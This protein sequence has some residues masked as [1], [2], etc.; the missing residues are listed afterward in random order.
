MS[1]DIS[2]CF[3]QNV[4]KSTTNSYRKKPT[5][6][7]FSKGVFSLIY[8]LSLPAFFSPTFA[9]APANDST[10]PVVKVATF[11]VS[12][13]ATNY[14]KRGEVGKGDELINSLNNNHQQ[15]K[16]IAEII[17][18]V[19]PDILLLNEFDYIQDPNQGIEKFISNYLNVSQ[20][21]AQAI[22]Y[23][24]YYYAPVNT[25]VSTNFDLDNNGEKSGNMADAYGFGHFPGHFGMVLVSRYPID[26]K[27]IRTFQ[28]F[29]WK[30]MPNAMKPT[31]PSTGKHWYSEQEWQALRLSSKSHWDIPVN[32]NGKVVHVLTSHP[33][34]PVFDGPEDRNGA[35]NHDEIRFWNDY[36][37][38]NKASYIY[39]DNG[40]KGGIITGASFVIMGDQNASPDEGSAIKSGI[41]NLLANPLTNNTFTP[42]S[43]GGEKNSES[44]FA[45][46][47]TAA[48]K[49]RADYV[50]PSTHGIKV[51]AAGV[52]WPKQDEPLY[53]LIETRA[54]SSDHRLVWVALMLNE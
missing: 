4:K 45:K 40:K 30:E 42:E 12:M 52:F 38:A 46:S 53:R 47:H 34:P 28:N 17:Q 5:K 50:I 13:D 3:T 32:V 36:I 8:L 10:T 20:Q 27:N 15:I 1:I 37:T 48:W 7:F 16:N 31:D 22:D 25:G 26:T 2:F 41:A 19:R 18:R 44:I 23:P 49:M 43:I 29:L 33:T 14:L 9:Q 11:N 51:K 6:T 35:R 24:Y 54:S 21:G 39:D